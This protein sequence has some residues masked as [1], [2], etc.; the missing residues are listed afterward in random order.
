MQNRSLHADADRV[1]AARAAPYNEQGCCPSHPDVQ[2]REW[3]SF[4]WKV[5]EEECY[6][7]QYERM[8]DCGLQPEIFMEND[9]RCRVRVRNSEIVDT[10]PISTPSSSRQTSTTA[11]V[12]MKQPHPARSRTVKKIVTITR[13]Y[14]PPQSSSQKGSVHQ[15][16]SLEVEKEPDLVTTDGNHYARIRGNTQKEPHGDQLV[17]TKVQQTTAT[18]RSGRRKTT[19][20]VT[21]V[22]QIPSLPF[23]TTGV[24]SPPQRKSIV[25]QSSHLLPRTCPPNHSSRPLAKEEIRKKS[26]STTTTSTT[27]TTTPGFVVGEDSSMNVVQL[28]PEAV[29]CSPSVAVQLM[30]D[31]SLPMAIPY[32]S[33]PSLP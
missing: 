9:G 31:I 20:T 29:A 17:N 21:T 30:D 1:V 15:H 13:Q 11:N 4:R 22:T 14:P 16:P 10:T 33:S 19:R 24:A 26:A 6:R 32:P 27:A 2:L 8:R 28:L 18:T 12:S 3:L 25:A 23:P 7:C 5:L